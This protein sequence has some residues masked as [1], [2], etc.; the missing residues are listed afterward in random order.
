M[1]NQPA[2]DTKWLEALEEPALFSERWKYAPE[3]RFYTRPTPGALNEL[4]EYLGICRLIGLDPMPWQRLA[5][6]IATEYELDNEG[7]R[8]YKYREVML[9]L[10]RQCGKTTLTLPLALLRCLIH[11]K[12][13][14]YFSAQTAQ[15]SSEFMR[16]NHLQVDGWATELREAFKLR[17]SNGS[18]GF[19]C[20]NKSSF[21]RFTRAAGA[22]HGKTPMT[23]FND[24]IW[25]MSEAEG[26]ELVGAIKP[27]QATLG[28]RSQMWNF[29]TMGT[30]ASDYMNGIVERG[31]AGAPGLAYIEYS[32][33]ENLPADDPT[34]WWSFHPA[35]GNTQDFATLY[36]D[37]LGL[38]E[39]TPGEWERA[40]CNRL[41]IA[42][43]RSVI[44]GWDKLETVD[45]PGEDDK[46]A[47]AVE[48]SS[49]SFGA[50]IAGAWKTSEGP[51]VGIIR[52]GNGL[53][54][55]LPTL[56]VLAEKYGEK[57]RRGRIK[58]FTVY[59]DGAG[60]NKRFIENL[61]K[62][63]YIELAILNGNQRQVADMNF[64]EAAQSDL[65][66]DNTPALNEGIA[67]IK[68]R[69][70]NGASR[71]DRDKSI[72]DAAPVLAASTALYGLGQQK[73][74]RRPIAL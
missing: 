25:V 30:I 57:T 45:T 12:S 4:N 23:V 17:R 72:N 35:L 33:D 11:P 15:Y 55:V 18:E 5:V 44:P 54:W 6:R 56:T 43:E 40:Y 42:D 36:E 73:T 8:R 13:Q 50:T 16:E 65:R 37:F 3:P 32:L 63:P 60:P 68:T 52:H 49:R 53:E 70:I 34:L 41:V 31:R 22:M 39:K 28:A 61:G 59:I 14:N 48:L 62:H 20:T 26:A 67:G 9:V 19:S 29:S 46:P 47:F 64:I 2:P 21:I 10:P 7:N 58:R 69:T 27:A 66:H 1:F 51:A 71:F 38:W 24:E 74:T